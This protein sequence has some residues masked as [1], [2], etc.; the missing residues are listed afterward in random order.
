MEPSDLESLSAPMSCTKPSGISGRSCRIIF[1][2][3]KLASDIGMPPREVP[4]CL[5]VPPRSLVQGLKIHRTQPPLSETLSPKQTLTW[6]SPWV[7]EAEKTYG[8][9]SGAELGAMARTV[10]PGSDPQNHPQI[11]AHSTWQYDPV[12]HKGSRS[13]EA[14]HR[15]DAPEAHPQQQSISGWRAE[16]AGKH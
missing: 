15:R 11:V 16:G 2:G 4:F 13:S 6:N 9:E 14:V 12:C 3:L 1:S 5:Y 8:P 7:L 10:P